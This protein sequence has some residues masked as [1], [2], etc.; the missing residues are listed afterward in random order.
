MSKK[1]FTIKFAGPAGMG[2]KS[3]GQL[4]S[5]ILIAHDFNLS[6]YSEYPSLVRGGHN[7]CQISFSQDKVFAPHYFIDILFSIVPN[8]W[9]QHLGEFTKDTLIFSDEQI[10]QINPEFNQKRKGKF[11]SLPLKTLANEIG[12]AQVVN[13][14]SLGVAAYLFNFDLELTKTIV[15]GFY[16]NFCDLNARAIQSGYDYAKTNFSKYKLNLIYK[17]TTKTTDFYEGNEAYSLGFLAGKG[18]FYCAYPMTPATGALH[19][20]AAKQEAYPNLKV[21]HAEDEV[22]VANMAVGAAFA[23][24]RTAV[25]TSGGGFALMNEAMS[26]CGVSEVGVVYYLVSRPGPAT[27]IP[28]YTAQADLLHAINSGHGEFPKI[29]IAPGDIDESFEMGYQSL[30]LAAK[31]QTPVIVI[32][33]KFL[34]ESSTSTQD[35]TKIKPEIDLGDIEK[36]PN[37]DYK[38]YQYSQGGISPRT[39]PGTQ[40][41]QFLANSYEHDEYGFSTEDATTAK[42]MFDKRN[43]KY[44]LALKLAPKANLFGNKSAKKLIISWGSTKGPILEA[45]KNIKNSSDF[46][47]LQLKTLWPI[48]PDIK[49]IIDGFKEIIVIENNGTGQLVSI[50]KSQFDFNP[51]KIHLKYDGRPFFPE[52]IVKKLNN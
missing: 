16:K 14:I 49:K 31:I 33:D 28:T 48:N 6:D 11:L 27:G 17:P 19:F 29:V 21:I 35:L 7:T 46:A 38:R 34:G 15:C 47:F 24:A 23:G 39:I 50:L 10:D 30:N 42:K 37:S 5:K 9:P 8:H 2:I 1:V 13:T 18:D 25:G 20:L 44:K 3:V 51:Q 40:N 4:F 32:S 36:N 41:G 43:S 22:G 12:S 26:L 45:L 52:E